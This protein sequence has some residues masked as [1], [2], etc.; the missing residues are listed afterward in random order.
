VKIIDSHLHFCE[1]E[2]YF[3]DIAKLSRHENSAIHLLSEYKRLN[4]VT[5]VVMGNGA[6]DKPANYPS[7]LYYCAGIESFA[8]FKA[9]T[10]NYL[11]NIEKHLKNAKCV[12][13]KL[14]PGYEAFYVYD[15]ALAPLYKLAAKY[16]KPIAVHTGLTASGNAVLKY[17]H[18]LVIDEA[19]AK[20]PNNAF[21]MC[22]LGEPWF[23]DAV[24][25]VTKNANVTA[26]LSGMLEGK[27]K[28]FDKFFS[29]QKYYMDELS[30]RLKM[31][32][33]YDKIMFGTDWPLANLE[34]YIVFTKKIISEDFWNLVFFD[35]AKRIYKLLR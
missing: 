32:N 17:A 19:A 34:D 5:G 22:H 7:P 31:S 24:A 3:F 8:S 12:G 35:N 6:L 15:D 10:E 18:P 28:D 25:V 1:T 29:D 23:A 13:I 30:G 33:I 14:Y 21:V 11:K 4:I 9:N 27:I 26:D 16:K 2:Q 20:F